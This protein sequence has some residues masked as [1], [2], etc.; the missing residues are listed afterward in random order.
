MKY[1]EKYQIYNLKK[2]TL[3]K[4]FS[5]VQ[6][7]FKKKNNNYIHKAAYFKSFYDYA[8]PLIMHYQTQM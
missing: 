4:I 7:T 5:L 1:K 2:S 8:F 3:P 6:K